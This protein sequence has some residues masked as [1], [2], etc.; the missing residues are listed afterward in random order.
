ML[1]TKVKV[2]VKVTAGDDPK[3]LRTSHLK[4]EQT[5]FHPILVTG[6]FWFIDVL[7]TFWGQKIK[8]QGHSMRSHNRRQQPVEF[9]LVAMSG[10]VN[11]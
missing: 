2:K 11:K 10:N 5:E 6:I 9:H 1:P 8:D 4:T 3:T 7:T